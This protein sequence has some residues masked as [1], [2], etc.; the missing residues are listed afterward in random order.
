LKRHNAAVVSTGI[1]HVLAW[2]VVLWLVFG[3][4]YQAESV[5]AAVPGAPANE[6]TKTTATLI[7]VNGWCVLP[8]LLVPAALTGLALVT[9]LK[10]NAGQT[11]RRVLVW[12]ASVLLLGFCILGSF[13]IGIF[14]LPSALA[15][16]VSSILVSRSWPGATVAG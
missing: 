6:P 11:S 9:I 8:I 16:V 1:A 4:I 5:T 3:P 10:T 12:V 2:V 13:S 7:E 15:L 14:Y